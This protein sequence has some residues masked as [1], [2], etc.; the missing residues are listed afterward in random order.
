MISSKISL[1]L[2]LQLLAILVVWAALASTTHAARNTGSFDLESDSTQY[3]S[4]ESTD[5]TGLNITG[6]ISVEAWVKLESAGHHPVIWKNTSNNNDAGYVFMV[7]QQQ[8]LMRLHMK[9]SDGTNIAYAMSKES[10]DQH[11]GKWVH[12]AATWRAGTSSIPKLYINGVPSTESFA[13]GVGV[14]NIGTNDEALWIGK[15]HWDVPEE[16]FDGL[17]DEVRI[18][19]DVRTPSE[20]LNNM[21]KSFVGSKPNLQGNWNFNSSINDSTKNNNN[22]TN[23]GGTLSSTERIH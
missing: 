9:V 19:D 23:N 22:L 4:I 20:I 14:S 11:I 16:Y 17:I 1:I 12:I 2:K 5:Q 21:H 3:A 7:E 13:S 18:W 10:L 8:G 6:N 15:G